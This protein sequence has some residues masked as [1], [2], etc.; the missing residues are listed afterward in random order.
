V[1]QLDPWSLTFD[2]LCYG[3]GREQ[4]ASVVKRAGMVFPVVSLDQA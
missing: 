4:V 1:L 3:M 2:L